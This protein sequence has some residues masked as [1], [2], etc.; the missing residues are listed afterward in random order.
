[1]NNW[2][3]SLSKHWLSLTCYIRGGLFTN[4]LAT[5]THAINILQQM[6]LGLDRLLITYVTSFYT[7]YI[8]KER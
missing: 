8:L 7:S 3:L 2:T 4:T 5:N 6:A 1:M